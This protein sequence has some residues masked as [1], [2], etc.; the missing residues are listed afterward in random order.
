MSAFAHSWSDYWKDPWAKLDVTI[1]LSSLLSKLFDTTW[2]SVLRSVRIFRILFL[3]KR[4]KNLRPIIRSM[5]V[6]LLPCLNVVSVIVL[7]LCVF[8]VCAMNLYGLVPHGH[9]RYGIDARNNFD[10]FPNAVTFLSQMVAGH[11]YIH[12][13][14]ELENHDKA[15]PFLFFAIFTVLMQ[16]ILINLFVVILL[17]NFMKVSQPPCCQ[18]IHSC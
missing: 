11:P 14:Y 17:D 9:T 2:I 1:V 5:F 15:F 7:F 13:V 6:S 12:V 10:N 16:W 3:I 4:F 8:A 18:F